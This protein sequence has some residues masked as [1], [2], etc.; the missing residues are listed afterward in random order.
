[1]PR[2]ALGDFFSI[3]AEGDLQKAGLTAQ[4]AVENLLDAL[5][6]FALREDEVVVFN[7][8]DRERR[9]NAS[10]SDDVSGERAIWVEA[11]I[12]LA[13]DLIRRHG[14]LE[15]ID[16]AWEQILGDIERKHTPVL[17]V[18][19]NRRVG[20]FDVAVDEA[21]R[22]GDLL[23]GKGKNFAV[24]PI[25]RRGKID[26][27]V[28]A[29]AALREGATMAV[30]DLATRRRNEQRESSGLPLG[31]P[32]WFGIFNS[33]GVVDQGLPGGEPTG[34]KQKHNQRCE[35]HRGTICKSHARL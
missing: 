1:M 35:F 16:L 5:A 22:N 13:E 18:V 19:Q 8:P 23:F 26:G 32:G 15:G 6:A 12:R 34:E 30:G 17:I 29:E 33:A 3:G 4:L 11:H 20:D 9:L 24:R 28:V 7:R 31:L 2:D 27:E 14:A 21:A 25:Q 10:V